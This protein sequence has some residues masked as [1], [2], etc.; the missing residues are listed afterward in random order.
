MHIRIGRVSVETHKN[1]LKKCALCHS[2]DDNCVRR[3]QTTGLP[4]GRYSRDLKLVMATLQ[5][6][7]YN[8]IRVP[9]LHKKFPFFES[10]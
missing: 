6:N 2:A 8:V 5:W 4:R 10:Y 1:N 3:I 9:T 7:L